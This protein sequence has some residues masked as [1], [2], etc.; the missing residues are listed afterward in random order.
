MLALKSVHYEGLKVR[1]G[2]NFSSLPS[3]LLWLSVYY[4]LI[5][6]IYV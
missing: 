4:G 5:S 1:E 2:L 6:K 3:Y